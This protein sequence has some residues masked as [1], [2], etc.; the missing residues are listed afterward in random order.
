LKLCF[1]AKRGVSVPVTLVLQEGEKRWNLFPVLS[2]P[3]WNALAASRM[4]NYTIY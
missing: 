2:F 1:S 4:K 3:E